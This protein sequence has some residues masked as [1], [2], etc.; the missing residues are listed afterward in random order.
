MRD[1]FEDRRAHA[2]LERMSVARRVRFGVVA[3]ALL[4]LVGQAGLAAADSI[5]LKNGR[6]IRTPRTEVVGDKLV[7]LQYGAEITIPMD[8]V[9][10][11]EPDSEI[12][13]APSP[14]R[15]PASGGDSGDVDAD[16]EDSESGE[17][18]ETPAEDTPDY[19]RERVAAITGERAEL[20][21]QMVNL[22]REERAFLFS[23]RST[24]ETRGKIESAQD[25][26]AEL[27]TEMLELRRDARRRGIPPGWLRGT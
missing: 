23:H 7:F 17:E 2:N 4:A 27:D 19:W 11:I 21:A 9:D 20:Q 14:P 26:L 15:P 18:A 1:R 5:Y 22:R 16:S 24:A 25:R 3:A 10:R 12:E 8:L 13:E 6:V